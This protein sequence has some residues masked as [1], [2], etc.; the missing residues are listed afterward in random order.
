MEN[1]IAPSSG[2]LA[3]SPWHLRPPSNATRDLHHAVH[4][5]QEPAG[6]PNS[7]RDPPARRAESPR[8]LSLLVAGFCD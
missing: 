6:Q 4:L 3:S 7:Q 5:L 1:T 2:H 8:Q